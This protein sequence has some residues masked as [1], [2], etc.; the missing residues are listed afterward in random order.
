MADTIIIM[1]D[2]F[3]QQMG[4]PLE[5]YDNPTNEFVAGFIGEPPM[6]LLSSVIAKT[7]DGFFFTF[8]GSDLRVKVPE[9]YNSKVSDGMKLTLG[10]RPVDVII[11]E[12][13]SSTPVPVSIYENFGDERRI[14]IKVGENHLN[15][16]TAADVFYKHGDIIYLEFNSEK[17]H[18]FSIETG[19]VIK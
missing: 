16:T 17:T 11:T 14:S 9:R 6:N 19:A 1:K 10:V 12:R 2:G 15:L 5:V 8:T 18:L 7:Q 13:P 4:S 3:L